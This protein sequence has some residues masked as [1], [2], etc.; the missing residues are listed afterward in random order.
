M[1]TRWSKEDEQYLFD[2]AGHTSSREYVEYFHGKYTE[3]QVRDK[4]NR[5][6]V[7]FQKRIHQR[8][9]NQTPV[10]HDF[11]AEIDNKEKAYVLGFFV[12]DG[13]IRARSSG[14]YR[15]GFTSGDK[16]H[17]LLI[18]DL[19]DSKHKLY[20]KRDSRAK[21]KCYDLFVSSKTMVGNIRSLGYDARKSYTSTYPDIPSDLDSHFIRGVFDGDGCLSRKIVKG[22]YCYPQLDFNGSY[23]LVSE[24]NNR[25]PKHVAI[26]QVKRNMW[27]IGFSCRKAFDV[28]EWMY[29]DSDGLRLE[30]KYR[31]YEEALSRTGFFVDRV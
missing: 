4:L 6:H 8:Q 14:C 18:R 29:T 7:P 22:K 20:E 5:C 26:R 13:H 1:Y 31:R 28:L 11:F 2:S 24:I 10:N 23:C 27:K 15:V 17:L 21:T 25:L 19:L 16:D 12:A 30:R 3:T 9:R